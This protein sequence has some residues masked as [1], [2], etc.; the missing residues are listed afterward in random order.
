VIHTF[1]TDGARKVVAPAG[2]HNQQGAL[3]SGECLDD[4]MN[5]A[6]AAEYDCR[7]R[8]VAGLQRVSTKN[9]YALEPERLENTVFF[10]WME[11]RGDAH[12]WI[13]KDV[14]SSRKF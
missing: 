9:I 7:V 14:S 13:V 4:P 10:V 2:R 1:D 5:A 11:D 8:K 3:C 6:V 12:R